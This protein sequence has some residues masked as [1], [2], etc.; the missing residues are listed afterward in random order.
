MAETQ[1]M[2]ALTGQVAQMALDMQEQNALIASLKAK[3][4]EKAEV[5][6]FSSKAVRKQRIQ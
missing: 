4:E 3:V 5:N 1:A 2:E 6:T